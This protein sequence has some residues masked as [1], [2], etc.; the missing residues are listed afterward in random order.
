MSLKNSYNGIPAGEIKLFLE[1]KVLQYNNPAFII[2]DPVSIPHSFHE[3]RDKEIS[4]FLTATIA[5]GRRD[6]ILRSSRLMLDLMDSFPYEFVISASEKELDRL[7]GFVHRTFNG[8]DLAYF[9]KGLRNIYS[10]YENMEE[11]LIQGMKAGGSLKEGLSHLRSVFFSLPHS[12]RNE[13]HF[14]DV[15][16]G[17][18]G[19]RLNM[20]LRWMVRSDNGGVDFGMWQKISP[21]QLYIPLDLHTGNTARKLGILTRKQNDW[22]AVEELTAI[23]R[24]FDPKDPVKYDFAL[25]GLGVNERF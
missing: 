16:N 11:V 22:E 21:S 10:N 19:K 5:W 20:F 23:L 7:S 8:T 25:F 4:G 3:S 9:I 6:L 2:N 18:A 15:M 1:E 17:S 13:K 12:T 14:A 24:C